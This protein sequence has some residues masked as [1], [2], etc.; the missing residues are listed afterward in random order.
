MIPPRV[1]PVFV[2]ADSNRSPEMARHDWARAQL[3]VTI[4]LHF[5]SLSAHIVA[6][7]YFFSAGYVGLGLGVITMLLVSGGF[8]FLVSN[9]AGAPSCPWACA[10]LPLTQLATY[11]RQWWLSATVMG[12]LQL[13]VV[14]L[15]WEDFH[16]SVRGDDEEQASDRSRRR[17]AVVNTFHCKAIIG[18]FEG[19]VS[20]SLVLFACWTMD[21]APKWLL[22][23]GLVIVFFTGYALLE[24]DYCLTARSLGA[25]ARGV[26]AN[27]GFWAAMFVFRISEVWFRTN[28]HVAFMASF[29]LKVWWWWA[30][31]A[32]DVVYTCLAVTRYGGPERSMRLTLLC[33]APSIFVDV[34]YFV[35]SPYRRQA[36]RR[37]SLALYVRNAFVGL[38]V[39]LSVLVAPPHLAA[40]F[41]AHPRLSRVTF[42]S[43]LLY[44]I[45][46][47]FL[48]RV[49]N[50]D[51]DMYA[52]SARGS[53]DRLEEIK[54]RFCC[55]EER[56]VLNINIADS[57]GY[58]PL[59]LAAWEGRQRT[60][61]W[62]LHEGATPS[63]RL[64]RRRCARIELQRQWT[65][66]HMAAARG[67]H[68]ALASMLFFVQ[69][70][71]YQNFQDA[72]G[73]NP[74]HIAMAEGQRECAEVILRRMPAWHEQANRRGAKPDVAT[75]RL[76]HTAPDPCREER[77]HYWR[78]D[79]VRINS[80]VA[81]RWAAPGLCCIVVSSCGGALGRLAVHTWLAS[82]ADAPG[83]GQSGETFLRSL[84]IVHSDTG[85]QHP[86]WPTGGSP[87]CLRRA[88]VDDG[89]APLGEGSYGT[90]WHV[91]QRIGN[92]QV[93]C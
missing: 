72:E 24:V 79:S 1:F 64:P 75:L 55:A 28:A 26:D 33:C 89:G 60:V 49:S 34:F 8:L 56:V 21:P 88:C 14:A 40:S 78:Q 15:A 86:L 4:V 90:V 58:T 51:D 93:G 2:L 27:R 10:A 12:L 87:E 17:T 80:D 66:M 32:V 61:E 82:D 45:L 81:M 92:G 54:K 31:L 39:L 46:R 23:L 25:V 84:D 76:A 36:A 74:L 73:D 50:N 57:D 43:I 83:T 47:L 16:T 59:M 5:T 67:H 38:V 22:G 53:V 42:L 69:G 7:V 70:G 35:E 68:T 13:V 62:L 44:F 65:A 37:L 63:A 48:D 71:D 29:Y 91:R 30:L 52:A 11:S 9:K 77:P 18:T 41:R 3:A 19:V 6:L 85:A 20:S